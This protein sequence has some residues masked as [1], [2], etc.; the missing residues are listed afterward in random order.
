MSWQQLIAAV[1]ADMTAL[2]A[3]EPT[4]VPGFGAPTGAAVISNF[5]GATATLAQNS[6]TVAQILEILKANGFIGA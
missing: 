5:P 4:P 1:E 3:Q 2:Y 6:Q